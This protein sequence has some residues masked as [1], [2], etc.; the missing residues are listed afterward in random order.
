MPTRTEILETLAA[1]QKQ[2]M[3]FFQRLSPQ[4]LERPA[5]ASEVPGA[6]PWSAKDHFAHL[7]YNERNVQQLLRRI[8]VGDTQD[9]ILRS[10]YPAG[11]EMPGILGN[12]EALTPQEQ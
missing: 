8:L 1:S 4:D 9:A 3:A 7:A 11:M 6:V 12:W 5:T 2:V 10:Q